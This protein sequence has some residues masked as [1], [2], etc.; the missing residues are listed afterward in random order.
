MINE[1]AYKSMLF[2]AVTLKISAIEW[3]TNF[4]GAIT[5]RFVKILLDCTLEDFLY[6]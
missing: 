2:E 4:G 3:K 5:S 1:T 6:I